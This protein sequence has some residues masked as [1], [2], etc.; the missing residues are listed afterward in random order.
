MNYHYID[1]MIKERQRLE[2]EDCQRRRML[3][4]V[5]EQNSSSGELG[6]VPVLKDIYVRVRTIFLREQNISETTLFRPTK[7][8]TARK[9]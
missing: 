7:I 1:F 2:L 9:I 5:R 6:I 3:R 8:E 4:T